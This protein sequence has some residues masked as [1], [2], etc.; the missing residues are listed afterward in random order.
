MSKRKLV[1]TSLLMCCVNTLLHRGSFNLMSESLGPFHET[2]ALEIGQP[3]CHLIVGLDVTWW[4]LLVEP[5]QRF[6]EWCEVINKNGSVK[7]VVNIGVA[8]MEA[9]KQPRGRHE[10][11]VLQPLIVCETR[12]AS[13]SGV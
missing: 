9:K 3:I 2:Y 4:V 6:E 8:H 10:C 13:R 12:N 7:R 5:L 11:K 1:N